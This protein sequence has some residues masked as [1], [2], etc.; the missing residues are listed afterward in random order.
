MTTTFSRDLMSSTYK[1]DFADSAGFKRILFNPRRALQARELTQSQTIIQKDIERFA[2]NIFKDGAMVNPGG[3]TLNKN[4]QYVKIFPGD[5]GSGVSNQFP[6]T[7]V[8]GAIFEGSE[9]KVKAEVITVEHGITADIVNNPP[10][11]YVVYRGKSESNALNASGTTSV[12]FKI[13]ETITYAGS[14]YQVQLVDNSANRAMGNGVR[15]SISEGDFFT[16]GMFCFSPAQSIIVSRYTSSYTGQVGF[17]V[18]EDIVTASDDTTLFDNQG[19]FPNLAAP[20]AD[21]YRITLKIAKSQDDFTTSTFVYV[22]N[23][24]D[25]V[26]V[27]QAT[28]SNQYNKIND[29]VAKRTA[30]ESGDYVVDPFYMTL[31][32]ADTTTLTAAFSPGKAYING[33]RVRTPLGTDITVNKALTT[34]KG[35]LTTAQ[36]PTTSLGI[37]Y[38][39]YIIIQGS[40]SPPVGANTAGS[41]TALPGSTTGGNGRTSYPL[42]DLHNNVTP[43][44][45]TTK[46]GTCRVR[47]VDA[48]GADYRYFIFDLVMTSGSFRAVKTISATASTTNFST[49]RLNTAATPVAQIIDASDKN[50]FFQLPRTRPKAVSN[51]TFTVQRKFSGNI[52]G[53]TITFASGGG[54]FTNQNDW[55]L[56][57]K[58]AIVAPSGF[59]VAGLNTSSVTVTITANTDGKPV[60]LLAYVVDT[61]SQESSSRTKTVATK[62]VDTDGNLISVSPLGAVSAS[63]TALAQ[64]ANQVWVLA[65]NDIIAIPIIRSSNLA[66]GPDISDQFIFDN[67]QRDDHYALGRLIKKAGAAHTGDIYITYTHYQH[68]GGGNFFSVSSY[69]AATSTDYGII[70]AYTMKDGTIVNLR[71]VL[72]FRSAKKADGTFNNSGGASGGAI[73]ELPQNDTAI[74]GKVEY[75]LPRKDRL[76]ISQTGEIQNIEGTPSFTPTFPEIPPKTLEL[77]RTSLNGGTISKSDLSTKYME[78]KGYTMKDIG[79]IAKRVDLLE[80]AVTLSLLEID[81]NALEVLD[82]AGNNRTKSG[83]VVDNFKNQYIS[84]I[85]NVEYRA[86]IDPKAMKVRPGFTEE[87][88]GLIYSTTASEQTNTQLIGDTVYLKFKAGSAGMVTYLENTKVSRT[89]NVNP[90]MISDY[91]GSITLSPQSDEWKVANRA[92]AKVID[93]GDALNLDQALLFD[94]SEWGWLGTDAEGSNILE[95]S[96]VANGSEQT[97]NGAN[98]ITR[99]NGWINNGFDWSTTN[100]VNRVVASETIRTVV[101]GSDKVIDVAVI[102]FMRTRKIYFEAVG[103]RPSQQHFAFFDGVSVADWVKSESF[104][105][106]NESRVELHSPNNMT[107]HP[108]NASILTSD[109]NGYL[110]GSFVIP[111][112]TLAPAGTDILTFGTGTKEFLLLDIS[113]IPTPANNG[114]AGSKALASFAAAGVIQTWQ[115]DV[116]STRHLTIVGERREIASGRTTI[117]SVR[118]PVP[119]PVDRRQSDPLAQSFNV[120]TEEG[121]YAR[122][123]DLYFK[124]K[125]STLP[126]WIELR[127]LVNGYPAS[128]TIVPGSRKYLNPSAVNISDTAATATTFTFDE[129][130]YL[131]GFTEYAIVVLC[132][133]TDYLAWTSFMGD[134]E[135]NSSIRKIVA[136]PFLGSFFKSQNGTTWEA[137]QKQDLK[138]TLKRAAF[139]TATDGIAYFHNNDLPLQLLGKDPIVTTAGSAVVFVKHQNHNLIVGD[140]VNI[141]GTAQTVGA[142]TASLLNAIHVITHVDPTGYKFTCSGATAGNVTTATGGGV[143]VKATY[144]VSGSTVYPIIQYLTPEN[145]GLTATGRFY[146]GQSNVALETAYEVPAAGFTTIGLNQK[147][148]YANPI[149]IACAGKED[150]PIAAGGLGGTG[151][152]I[153]TG[154]YTSGSGPD[155][156]A[157]KIAMTTTSDFVSPIID[158]QRASLVVTKN[159]ID[160]PVASGTTGNIIFNYQA[161]TT[162][163]S[164][165]ALAKHITKPVTLANT[166]V[167]LKVF[168]GINRPTGS[169]VDLYYKVKSDDTDLSEINWTLQTVL[170]PVGPSDDL[171]VYREHEYLIEESSSFTTFQLKL[172]FRTNNNS[173]VPVVTDLRAIALAL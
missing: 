22:A 164:G 149:T 116:I 127:P 25:T 120:T 21:R 79:K 24:V 107:G 99:A 159:E 56:M 170:Q 130:V 169:F 66:A 147:N 16:Q 3:V 139:D 18:T 33:F 142:I 1:D 143:A 13:G 59:S 138:F 140:K 119:R 108:S 104:T 124:T 97:T 151:T 28:G 132:D 74:S 26:I 67:G 92:E 11:L 69:P 23:I 126:I 148:Y 165:S 12:K 6:T 45:N 125:S 17:K 83:F 155:T 114:L 81:T 109:V 122:S 154:N 86:S 77:Y 93:G 78:N 91:R 87:N 8:P 29:L 32:D 63:Q 128:N 46:V 106:V 136:Q 166:A 44:G 30:E 168:L 39:N 35:S 38:G 84:D 31:K 118:R 5:L 105:R 85:F 137:S 152:S 161:E 133:N 62:G 131:S 158:L 55:I 100:V 102:P 72:D 53:S 173:K 144:N 103:L 129:P 171:N 58:G 101:P 51:V 19:A 65:H 42:M 37:E 88:I 68:G 50:L 14:T 71:D 10:T 121:I 153:E 89:E 73:H 150:T 163:F 40:G 15:V 160:N 90:F 4:I 80:E 117:S 156:G 27:E 110:S 54:D 47:H 34:N 70:P 98:T 75:Y 157:I 2:R 145:T 146:S 7:I 113:A 76:I 49:L 60:E 43:N 48:I 41:V 9:S 111:H 141:D 134:N 123:V 96:Q 167:G 36:L 115:E 20:G 112:N 61:V 162:P 82:A 95:A 57:H 172:V 135:L 64:V 94:Q 52:S